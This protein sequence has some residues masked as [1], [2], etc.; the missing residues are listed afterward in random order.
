MHDTLGAASF[1]SGRSLLPT[2][3]EPGES[4]PGDAP[5]GP[6]GAAGQHPRRIGPAVPRRIGPAV[7]RAGSAQGTT[8]G[9]RAIFV[10][11][12]A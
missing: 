12:L 6:G 1:G 11:P 8:G 9:I 7:R 4:P 10:V 2:S 3:P 5:V